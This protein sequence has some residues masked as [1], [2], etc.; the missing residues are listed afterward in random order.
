MT[1]STSVPAGNGIVT[2]NAAPH[3]GT[4]G[5]AT[6]ASQNTARQ[7]TSANNVVGVHYKIGRKIGEGSF[8]IIY[9]G[10]PL[11]LNQALTF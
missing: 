10:K 2:G 5:S 6:G 11:L 4:S 1:P 8:G 3:N 7:S 9:E